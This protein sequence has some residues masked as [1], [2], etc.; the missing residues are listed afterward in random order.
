MS[1]RYTEVVILAEDERSANLLRRY[2]VRA[3]GLTNR[4]I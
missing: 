2:V 4:R 1:N 3:L